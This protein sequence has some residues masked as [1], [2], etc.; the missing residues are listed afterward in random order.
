MKNTN[1]DCTVGEGKNI[2]KNV[3]LTAFYPTLDIEN[4]DEDYFDVNGMKLLTL[5]DYLDDRTDYITISMDAKLAIPYG[6]NACIPEFNQHFNKHINFEI[7]D[8]GSNVYEQG[9]NRVDICVRSEADSYDH[10]V[11]LFNATL[12]I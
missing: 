3:A 9:Y 11:N 4:S 8:S 7:R 12:V 10:I 2:Y 6:T 1:F 5:Q